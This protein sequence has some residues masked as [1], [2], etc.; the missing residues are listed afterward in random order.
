MSKKNI[1]I[2]LRFIGVSIMLIAF[3]VVPDSKSWYYEVLLF[4]LGLIISIIPKLP[5][6]KSSFLKIKVNL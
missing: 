4:D 5:K 6:L 2:T 1:Y 3:L